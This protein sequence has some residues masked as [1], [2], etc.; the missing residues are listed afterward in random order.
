MSMKKQAI[1]CA[2]RDRY[3]KIYGDEKNIWISGFALSFE[4]CIKILN[5]SAIILVF[6]TNFMIQN[7]LGIVIV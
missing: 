6:H 2:K 7:S 5:I 1:D 3:C 4:L